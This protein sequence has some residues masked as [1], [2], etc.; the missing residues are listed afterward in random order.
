MIHKNVLQPG[1][2]T[3]VLLCLPKISSGF[4]R[5]RYKKNSYRGQNVPLFQFLFL[6]FGV[7]PLSDDDE[8]RA[9]GKESERRAGRPP[10]ADGTYFIIPKLLSVS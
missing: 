7:L 9:R 10:R 6:E 2:K 3:R 8:M 1:H 4:L 5:A